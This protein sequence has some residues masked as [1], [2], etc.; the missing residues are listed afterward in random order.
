MLGYLERFD[1]QIDLYE[2]MT[3][4]L[5]L[6]IEKNENPSISSI[7]D[8][9]VQ[10]KHDEYLT[11]KN[12]EFLDGLDEESKEIRDSFYRIT[13]K[14]IKKDPS[15][16]KLYEILKITEG[17]DDVGPII[18]SEVESTGLLSFINNRWGKLK[19]NSNEERKYKLQSVCITLCSCLESLCS[20]LLK[21]YF[22]TVGEDKNL[23]EKQLTYKVIK[24]FEIIDDVRN[25]V[26][27]EH[28]TEVFRGS[29]TNWYSTINNHFNVNKKFPIVI[30]DSEPIAEFFQRRN[31][32]VHTGGIVSWYYIKNTSRKYNN[33]LKVGDRIGISPEYIFENI[34]LIRK[35]G[36][37]IFY[38]FLETKF[39]ENKEF[40]PRISAYILDR[41]HTACPTIPEIYSNIS[42][43]NFD[44][45]TK[46]IAKMNYFL[47]HKKNNS[48]ESVRKDLENTDVSGSSDQFVMAKSIL[49]ESEDRFDICKKYFDSISDSSFLYCYD[50]PLISL[51]KSEV[52]FKNYFKSR[53]D[54]IFGI[55]RRKRRVSNESN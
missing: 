1:A 47:F 2:K 26:I 35:L 5:A 7:I 4:E 38:S 40:A 48:F 49:L 45:Q 20:D 12:P 21:D 52:E 27:D 37:A 42:S 43:G 24:N 36:Y 53:I 33:G 41:M 13:D 15:I 39:K 22:L 16:K 9:I 46:M 50:W 28:L 30:N 54:T 18:T 34:N 23:A 19:P 6:P 14:V 32:F 31:L 10:R 11:E 29:Y 8:I 3:K 55:R 17:E 25:F 44:T 51:V